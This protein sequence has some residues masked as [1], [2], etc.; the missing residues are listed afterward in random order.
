MISSRAIELS[1]ADTT[2]LDHMDGFGWGMMWVGWL[3]TIAA[4][5]LMVWAVVRST[6]SSTSRRGEPTASAERILADRFARG[7]IDSD[8]YRLRLEELQR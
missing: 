4:I 6:S 8:E 1:L 7:E 2:G 3:V 5:G